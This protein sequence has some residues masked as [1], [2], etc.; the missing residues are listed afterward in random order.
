MNPPGND[1]RI[2]SARMPA[3]WSPH[4]TTWVSWPHNRDT[5]P[6]NL[7]EAQQ[8]FAEFVRTIARDE[9]VHVLA[10]GEAM[11]SAI[12]FLGETD[13]ITLVDIR[14]NDA[15]A[16][17]YGPTFVIGENASDISAIDWGYNAWGGK[18]P[19]FELDQRV[20]SQIAR[21]IGARRLAPGFI[22][23]GGAIEINSRGLLL[24]TASCALNPNRNPQKPKPNCIRQFAKLS[25]RRRSYG[26]RAIRPLAPCCRATTRMVISISSL[27]LLVTM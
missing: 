6:K 7:S 8:E 17:D 20:G 14:T 2:P 12:E 23:E 13:G 4:Q 10:G 24:T 1:S 26:Y 22:L 9:P 11:N 25:A 27:V 18:Y 5:W 19:P 16:R 15:W 21:R 3:E